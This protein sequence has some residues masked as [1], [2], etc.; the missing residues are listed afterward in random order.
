MRTKPDS[1][2][3]NRID[4]VPPSAMSDAEIREAE[5]NI[6]STG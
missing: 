6:E 1:K 5:D 4:K 2:E 3:F